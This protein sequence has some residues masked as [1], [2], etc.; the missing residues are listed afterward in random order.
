SFETIES[1]GEADQRVRPTFQE[2]PQDLWIVG[3]V[4][5]VGYG[6]KINRR[7][8]E[9]ADDDERAGPGQK[10]AHAEYRLADDFQAPRHQLE[11]SIER[12]LT[13]PRLRKVSEG[14][15]A[16]LLPPVPL[17]GV[18]SLLEPCGGAALILLLQRA[19]A[20]QVRQVRPRGHGVR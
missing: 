13:E 12:L 18:D 1:S 20:G 9:L 17:I 7:L 15:G 3:G 6:L 19:A 2:R 4:S 14:L 5:Q 8:I 16:I 10:Q 11:P